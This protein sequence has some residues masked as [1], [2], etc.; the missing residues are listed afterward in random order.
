MSDAN[1]VMDFI[2]ARLGTALNEIFLCLVDCNFGL[3]DPE[4]AI[5]TVKL[6]NAMVREGRVDRPT[7]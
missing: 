4:L 3:E 2:S 7:E 6:L 5:F 1:D